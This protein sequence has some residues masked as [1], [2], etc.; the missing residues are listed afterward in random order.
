[1]TGSKCG[2]IIH[3]K[4]LAVLLFESERQKRIASDARSTLFGVDTAVVSSSLAPRPD[5][6][7]EDSEGGEK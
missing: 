2:I 5:R 7:T 1:M 3:T 4:G 6:S